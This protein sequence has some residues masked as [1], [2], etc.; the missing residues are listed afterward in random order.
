MKYR[1]KVEKC[2]A[3]LGGATKVCRIYGV[4]HDLTKQALDNLYSITNDILSEKK[5]IIIGI[6]GE[7]IVFE[8]GP[9]YEASKR[10]KGFIKHLK[11]IKIQKIIFG[12]GLRKEELLEFIQIIG[13]KMKLIHDEGGMEK[14]LSRSMIRHIKIG[15]IGFTH[16]AKLQQA[17]K[18]KKKTSDEVDGK[19]KFDEDID[20]DADTKKG[21]QENVDF[22]KNTFENVKG[23]ESLSVESARHIVSSLV[24]SLIRNKS[25]LLMLTSLRVQDENNFADS[26]NTA[27]FTLMQAEMLGLDKKYLSEVGTAALLHDIGKLSSQDDIFEEEGRLTEEQ[28]KEIS[29]QDIRGA[30]MLLETEGASV[31]AAIVA[32]EHNI[33]YDMSGPLKKRYGKDLN[34]ISMMIAISNHYN[35]LRNKSTYWED[36][37]P[38]KVYEDMMKL[39]GKKF[40]PDMLNNFFSSLGVYPPG[41]LVELDNKE[42]GLVIQGSV[43]DKKRPQVEILYDCNGEKHKEPRIVNLLE[44]DRK[45]QYKWSI[46]RSISPMEKFD[47]PEKYAT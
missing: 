13:M 42:I 8:N 12:S 11:A 27:I 15:G 9:L 47:I 28:Q 2:V 36:G 21:Y 23:N 20:V 44:R 38:E 16:D 30:K 46:T 4:E 24:D 26:V 43:L 29:L 25:L 22:I 3:W 41:T 35:K 33:P 14:I 7:E 19:E 18:A 45:G 34:V 40:N 6:I 37:G 1:D 39:S 5:Q 31:L 17:T 32:F 10:R